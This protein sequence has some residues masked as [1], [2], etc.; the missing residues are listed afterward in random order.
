M[1]SRLQIT[2]PERVRRFDEA[3]ERQRRRQQNVECTPPREV[4]DGRARSSMT[5]KALVE[6]D[7]P[8]VKAMCRCPPSGPIFHSG[9]RSA[10]HIRPPRRV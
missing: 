4:E 7:H 2:V 10:G 8:G 1:T 6:A 5:G 3:T 9:S